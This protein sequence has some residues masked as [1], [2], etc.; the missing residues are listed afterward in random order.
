MSAVAII[1]AKGT[2]RRVPGKNRKMF[3]GHPIIY[4]SIKTAQDSG[5]FSRIVVSTDDDWIGRY[6]EGCGA[7]W[8]TRAE[9]LTRDDVGTQEVAVDVLRAYRFGGDPYDYAC[10]IYPCAPM[11]TAEDLR[12]G[13]WLLDTMLY[14]A[15]A[16]VPG[17][18]YWGKT[19]SFLSELS[20]P[21]HS[22]PHDE[23]RYIDINTPDDWAKAE[24]MYSELFITTKGT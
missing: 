6:S 16:Y 17:W 14:R 15:F 2:S 13:R 19:E 1:P 8:F 20:L 23:R 22:V 11:M 3:H 9:S 21:V 7:T 18:Y 4:Y 24:Q 5:L 10:C 12:E